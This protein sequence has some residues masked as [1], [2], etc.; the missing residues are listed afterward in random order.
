MFVSVNVNIV[1]YY[2]NVNCMSI[3]VW[4]FPKKIFV[5]TN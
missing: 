5:R 4:E 1:W 2:D 3:C